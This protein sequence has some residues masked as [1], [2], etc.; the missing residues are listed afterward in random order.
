MRILLALLFFS[1]TIALP[2]SSQ[3]RPSSPRGEASTQVGGSYADGSYSGGSWVVVDYGR[4]ILRGRVDMFGSGESYG[5]GLYAGA[6][7]WRAG[8]NVS[9]R[10]MTETDLVFGDHLLK[11]GEYS[12]FVEF[13][14]G[15]WT[16]IV[17]SYAAKSS[18]RS[19]EDGLW[20][21]YNYTPEKDVLRVPMTL[22]KN[23]RS[24]DQLTYLFVNMTQ[25]GGTLML[26]WDKEMA[27]VDF[28]VAGQ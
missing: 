14:N 23:S 3:D 18:G 24:V 28:S 26:M 11:A 2:A 10:I 7:V 6:P 27:S 8:A 21:S 20:G 15:N 5:K 22:T 9:T 16:L 19:E 12:L 17:S 25:Q 4:P 13:E 1:L